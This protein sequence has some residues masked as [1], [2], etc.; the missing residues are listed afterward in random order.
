MHDI[1]TVGLAA[2]ATLALIVVAPSPAAAEK[3]IYNKTGKITGKALNT[4]IFTTKAGGAKVECTGAKPEGETTSL[5]FEEL[6]LSVSHSGCKIFGIGSATVSLADYTFVWNQTLAKWSLSALRTNVAIAT[7]FPK[8]HI[9]LTFGQLFD[10]GIAFK[11]TTNGT[12]KKNTI[13]SEINIS[14]VAS[15]VTESESTSLCG[16]VGEK[17]TTGT[18]TGN[19]EIEIEGEGNNIEVK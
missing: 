19:I 12:T 2:A 8:C 5:N 14:G 15:E 18:Y 16:T 4:Q 10:S 1:K 17:N 7:T 13:V 11:N 6:Q 3:F 9:V